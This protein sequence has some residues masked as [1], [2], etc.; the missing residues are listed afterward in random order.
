MEKILDQEEI[1]ALFHAA[2]DRAGRRK[3]AEGQSR[4]VSTCNFRRAG[5]MTRDQLSAVNEL[6]NSFVRGLASS[7]A[8][9]LRIAAE[10]NLVSTEQMTY[11][12]F[13]QRVPEINY[14]VSAHLPGLDVMA[15]VVLDLQIAF[16]L[17]DLLL[18]G[19]GSLMPELREITE[20]EEEI[21][22]GISQTVCRELQSTWQPVI[23]TEINFDGRQR[24][25][26]IVRLMPPNEKV[27][28]L[29]F[30]IR[31]GKPGGMLM[32][33][34]PAV[35][36]TA[37]MRK[38]AQQGSYRKHRAVSSV[39]SNLREKLGKCAFPIELVLPG[40]AVSSQQLLD[41][42]EGSVLALHLKSNQ[43]AVLYVENQ[44]LFIAQ[45]VR[46]GNHRAGQIVKLFSIPDPHRSENSDQ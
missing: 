36:V 7:L 30:E 2:Q 28:S 1:D 25:T 14:V 43:P 45:P 16:P 35:A 11:G 39:T 34:F 31:A 13:L 21:L 29:S 40:G 4:P 38:L 5:M 3:Q 26:Q 23:D 19:P 20:V 12:E 27:L 17:I 24:Q 44:P 6:H 33:A 22:K 42:K 37:L 9:Q 8:A 18:G 32:T 15:A 46:S 10:V 41:L